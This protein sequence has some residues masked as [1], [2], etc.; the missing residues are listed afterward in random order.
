MT[1]TITYED[2]SESSNNRQTKSARILSN[3]RQGMEQVLLRSKK[4]SLD[5]GV[6]V[7]R[8]TLQDLA[9]SYSVISGFMRYWN[10]YNK[11]TMDRHLITK[12]S[13]DTQSSKLL[14]KDVSPFSPEKVV[15]HSECITLVLLNDKI[16]GSKHSVIPMFRFIFTGKVYY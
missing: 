15:F 8:A 5:L 9:V 16:V 3:Q 4:I 2:E 13:M 7:A 12:S 14:H 6:F 10:E 11:A 1:A